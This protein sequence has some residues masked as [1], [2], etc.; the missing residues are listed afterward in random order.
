MAEITPTN[1]GVE[2]NGANDR[3]EQRKKEALGELLNLGLGITKHDASIV[4]SVAQI[5]A[6][7][8]RQVEKDPKAFFSNEGGDVQAL[9]T[10][11]KAKSEQSSAG[12]GV[13]GGD[14]VGGLSWSDIVDTIKALE[15]FL[16]DE[17]GFVMD[18]LRLIF[19]GC[20]GTGW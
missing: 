7:L 18:I 8:A 12:P 11:L 6:A 1:A 13:S 10:A 16:K 2:K 5:M 19:C 17:K 3:L 14:I 20:K 4:E 9:V 15:G